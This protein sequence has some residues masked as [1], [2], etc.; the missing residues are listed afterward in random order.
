MQGGEKV[1]EA[2]V[3]RG[4]YVDMRLVD[5]EADTWALCRSGETQ[6]LVIGTREQILDEYDEAEKSGIVKEYEK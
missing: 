2:K 4:R 1:N 6:L 5:A 3:F